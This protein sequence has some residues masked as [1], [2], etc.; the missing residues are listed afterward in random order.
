MINKITETNINN[1]VT[2]LLDVTPTT[3]TVNTVA[4]GKKFVD[5]GGNLRNGEGVVYKQITPPKLKKTVFTARYRVI[6]TQ[7]EYDLMYAIDKPLVGYN[8]VTPLVYSNGNETYIKLYGD[9]LDD[10]KIYQENE[11]YPIAVYDNKY[12]G[13]VVGSV[14]YNQDVNNLFSEEYRGIL[15]SIYQEIINKYETFIFPDEFITERMGEANGEYGVYG[16]T[17]RGNRIE[18]IDGEDGNFY[19]GISNTQASREL[20]QA[21]ISAV[22]L[23]E[24]KTR[25][26]ELKYEFG[27]YLGKLKYDVSDIDNIIET[28]ITL[29]TLNH[30]DNSTVMV[31]ANT[32]EVIAGKTQEEVLNSYMSSLFKST[33]N[34]E[35][36][37]TAVWKHFNDDFAG[38]VDRI[39][40]ACLLVNMG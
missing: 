10:F 27:K 32:P 18:V 21:R 13:W 26:P 31:N 11:L 37:Y 39:A 19:W 6:P 30:I 40:Y 14:G 15:G 4:Q 28:L 23:R 24:I 35:D 29:R 2:S 7:M 38:F 20:L 9:N 16:T 3:A 17:V 33:N 22:I 36:N 34:K 25:L 5:N 1:E 8:G 12:D